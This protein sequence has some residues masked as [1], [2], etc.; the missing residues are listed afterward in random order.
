MLTL[1]VSFLHDWTAFLICVSLGLVS[2]ELE[3]DACAGAFKGLDA[4][5]A[6]E[7][8]LG[9]AAGIA[10]PNAGRKEKR[11]TSEIEICML[12]VVGR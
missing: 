5:L 3:A 8:A 2:A 10:R 4:A 11:R 9:A 12:S 6:V 1:P 7:L